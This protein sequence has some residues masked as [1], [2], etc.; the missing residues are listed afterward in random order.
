MSRTFNTQ[1]EL[2][3]YVA[4]RLQHQLEKESHGKVPYLPT[5]KPERF[6]PAH[7]TFSDW[8]LGWESYV[9]LLQLPKEKYFGILKTFLGTETLKL[10]RSRQFL[11]EEESEW[12]KTVRPTLMT[13]LDS[14]KV[15]DKEALKSNFLK[16]AQQQGEDIANFGTRVKRS[17]L[18]AYGATANEDLLKTVFQNGL[19]D[20]NLVLHLSMWQLD[21]TDTP[22]TFAE[23]LKRAQQVE[24]AMG[25]NASSENHSTNEQTHD[26]LAVN[27]NRAEPSRT[28]AEF[29]A[30]PHNF[31]PRHH[32]QAPGYTNYRNTNPQQVRGGNV[33]QSEPPRYNRYQETRTCFYCNRVGHI[34]RDC[35]TKQ[36]DSNQNRNQNQRLDSRSQDIERS[37]THGCQPQDYRQHQSP[38]NPRSSYTGYDPNNNTI[39]ATDSQYHPDVRSQHHSYISTMTGA[40]DQHTAPTSRNNPV[41]ENY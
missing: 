30:E 19:R 40:P 37:N 24:S 31:E 22:K 35:R 25:L 16:I 14:D 6:N 36:R 3:T 15:V 27:R 1:E 4:E 12:D 18:E 9:T 41:S 34:K 28:R 11:T 7:S 5:R 33:R 20:R 2:E 8:L 26:I 29:P 13:L 23:T 21:V 38:A 10:I 32:Q 39:A 17:Y